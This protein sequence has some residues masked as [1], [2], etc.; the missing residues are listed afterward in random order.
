MTCD[1]TLKSHGK[2]KPRSKFGRVLSISG[3]TLAGALA[4]GNAQAQSNGQCETNVEADDTFCLEP[5][6]VT[7][8]FTPIDQGHLVPY[9]QPD[10]PRDDI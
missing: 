7:P 10:D 5:I 8:F 1:N 6:S 2:E 3:I 4:V 9:F